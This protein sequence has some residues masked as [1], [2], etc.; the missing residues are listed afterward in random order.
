MSANAYVPPESIVG[1]V[2]VVSAPD[3]V[4]ALS[5]GH[6]TLFRLM[7][8]NKRSLE[9]LIHLARSRRS[10]GTAYTCTAATRRCTDAGGLMNVFQLTWVRL[11]TGTGLPG[12]S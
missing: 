10:V 2:P 8:G 12:W 4:R 9:P 11:A 6:G 5:G 1:V 3:E 7:P